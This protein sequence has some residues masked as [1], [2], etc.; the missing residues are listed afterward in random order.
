M[1]QLF[2]AELVRTLRDACWPLFTNLLPAQ[3]VSHH[4]QSK[5]SG[6][7]I[8]RDRLPTSHMAIFTRQDE[9]FGQQQIPP[10][11][12]GVCFSETRFGIQARTNLL[13]QAT[14]PI[15]P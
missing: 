12:R 7:L 15:N 3:G 9:V 11:N 10:H 1:W 2:L 13:T 8:P 5:N 6:H 14:I 4:F